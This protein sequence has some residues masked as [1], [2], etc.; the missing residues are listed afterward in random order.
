MASLS[1]LLNSGVNDVLPG[2]TL[3]KWRVQEYSLA[4][5][6]V[7]KQYLRTAEE[8][9]RTMD[10]AMRVSMTRMALDDVKRG[11]LSFGTD[12]FDQRVFNL[13]NLPYLLYLSLRKA[14]KDITP[15]KA[16]ELVTEDNAASLGTE[17]LVIQ[18]YISKDETQSSIR[19]ASNKAVLWEAMIDGLRKLN[20]TF[21][22]I[23]EMTLPQ[24]IFEFGRYEK[25]P[26]LTAKAADA[27]N[28]IF[29]A[30]LVHF[31]I[32]KLELAALSLDDVKTKIVAVEPKLAD[33]KMDNEFLKNAIQDY[34]NA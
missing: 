22:Q 17:I 12:N 27:R 20:F 34:L 28:R 13:A 21:E 4:E 25:K 29:D 3:S 14:H 19:K 1:N 23:A 9:S 5:E 33:D 7:A 32:S 31:K 15:E 18:G 24:I 2:Y 6:Y 8:S 16:A 11:E 30:I 10:T 26:E